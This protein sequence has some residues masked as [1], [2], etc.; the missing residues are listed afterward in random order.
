[1]RKS[2]MAC[3]ALLLAVPELAVAQSSSKLAIGT[4]RGDASRV[5]R[6]VLLQLCGPYDCVAASRVTTD[7]R[8][9]PQK[10]QRAGVSGYLGGAVTGEPG[11]QR[12]ILTLITPTST[13][14]KPARIWR[15]RLSPDGQLRPRVMER[16][17]IE[18]D[19]V[20]QGSARQAP[21]P[22][23]PPQ[24][25]PAR[26]PPPAAR[27]A[28]TP[29]P[30]PAP[31]AARAAPPPARPAPPPAVAAQPTEEPRA[32]REGPVRVAGE[33]GLWITG[34]KLSYSGATTG[35]T[36]LRT[37]SATAIFVPRLRLEAYPAAFVTTSRLWS[38]MGIYADYG[39]SVGLKVK[40]PAGSPEGN[41]KGS[42]TTLDAGLVWRLQPFS[43]S[44]FAVAPALGYRSLRLVTS[45]KIDGLPDARL[46]GYQLRVD[47][48]AP[49]TSSLTVLGGGGYTLWTSAKDLVKGGYFSKG[50]ARGW[51]VEAGA[52]YRL[53]GPLSVKGLLEYQS[54]S[55]SGLDEPA[56]G[57]GTASGAKETYLGGRVMLRGEF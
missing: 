36:P 20:L 7:G 22:S 18:L 27:P 57:L 42:L 17:A 32:R 44:R 40:P 10:L 13:A 38:G 15:L 21:A 24:R 50:S 56:A 4:I 23:A 12:V 48:S 39:Q 45:P 26:P 55:Y 37:F 43:G 35:T 31:P 53:F 2:T 25:L 5:R 14:R 34:R 1:M 28:P 52:A 46:S 16:F 41:H 33:A 19:E 49:V 30:Q 9:D 3:V 11:Q 6:Q 8:P 29:P 54:T 47:V 51:Q